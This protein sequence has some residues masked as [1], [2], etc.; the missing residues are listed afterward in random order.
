MKKSSSVIL[1]LIILVSCS[2]LKPNKNK[3]SFETP[4]GTIKIHTNFYCDAYEIRN[5]DWREFM[6][7][8]ENIFGKNSN[9]YLSTLPD[10]TVWEKRD[11]SLSTYVNIYLFHPAFQEYPVIGISQEQARAYSKWRSNRV[12][13]MILVREGILEWEKDQD[14]TNYFTIE[15]YFKGNYKNIAPD[16]NYMYFPV[17]KLPT[18]EERKIIL[19]YSDSIE[20]ITKKI[21]CNKYVK[22]QVIIHCSE[23]TIS[24]ISEPVFSGCIPKEDLYQIRGNVSEWLEEDGISAGGSWVDT[25]KRILETDTFHTKT[26]NAW[27]GFRNVFYWEKWKN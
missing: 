4:P 25:K 17:Y 18:I 9:E 21:K 5:V 2:I 24:D 16:S 7:W 14:S 26:V 20:A 6:Y 1:L 10:T 8:N 22:S 23:D 11:T 19:D 13:E 3:F 15:K 27:T 12:M